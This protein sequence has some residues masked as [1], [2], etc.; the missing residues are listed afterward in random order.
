MDNHKLGPGGADEIER[1][2]QPRSGL[3]RFSL[4][5]RRLKP[6]ATDS[7]ALRALKASRTH[8]HGFCSREAFV[9]SHRFFS[10]GLS[11]PAAF[12]VCEP[13]LREIQCY[14]HRLA[15]WNSNH[16]RFRRHG[17]D[18]VSSEQFGRLR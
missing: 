9:F 17:F 16:A 8:F 2:S 12:S 10:H 11:R 4:R 14:I 6:T 13:L 5:F 1:Y 15:G 3:M 18:A 7:T